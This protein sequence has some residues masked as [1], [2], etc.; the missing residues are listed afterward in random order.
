MEKARE[1][2]NK[3]SKLTRTFPDKEKYRLSDQIIRSSR[4]VT[5]NIAE[6]YGKFTYKETK[7]FCIHARGSLNETLNHLIDAFDEEYITKE[8]LLAY[9]T[10][11]E[12]YLKL[13]NG[14]ITFLKK[15]IDETK[16][17]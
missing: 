13:L 4:S 9:K 11:I 16:P 12:E 5:A 1:L 7:Q 3:V 15:K 8:Q 10:E 2:K 6:G 14:Y 17:I